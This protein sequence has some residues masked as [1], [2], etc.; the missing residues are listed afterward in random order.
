[1]SDRV[2]SDIVIRRHRGASE[3][4]VCAAMMAESEPWGTLGMGYNELLDM[5]SDP[6]REVYLAHVDESIL[7]FVVVEMNGVFTGYIKSICV[8]SL[9]R[10]RGVGGLLM[11]YAEHRV[12]R[13]KPNVFLCVSGFNVAAQ[14][15]YRCLGYEIVGELKDY[16]VSGQSE[17]LMRKTIAPLRAF[18]AG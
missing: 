3:L 16:L 7:G 11:A 4:Y 1:M 14:G 18:T 10:G 9:H 2:T 13:E 15:F 5:V 17:I 8:S 6:C 12:F